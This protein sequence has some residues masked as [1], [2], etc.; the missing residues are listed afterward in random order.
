LKAE[1]P[2]GTRPFPWFVRMPVKWLVFA[3]V[4]LLVLFPNPAQ[5]ARH[6]SRLRNLQ[7]M[8]EPNA[9]ELAPFEEELRQRLAKGTDAAASQPA[10]DRL[11]KPNQV[12]ASQP[13]DPNHLPARVIQSAIERFVF[14]KVKYAWDWDVWG[15]ADYIPTIHEM[16]A[17]A[18]EYPD[19][20]IRE[21]C[22]GRAVMAAS[23][24]KRMGYDASI[25]TDL[26]HVW[27]TT[28]EGEWMGPGGPKT[29]A[30]GP[31]GNRLNLASVWRNVPVSLSYGIAVFP[32][33]REMILLL[34]AYAL[35]ICRRISWRTA[36]VAGVLLLQGLL[37]MRCGALAFAGEKDW[38]AIVGMLHVACGFAILMTA[39]HRARR[40]A[41]T[42]TSTAEDH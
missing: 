30:S 10:A 17:K 22:D 5:L 37:F 11:V 21:D 42:G 12:A 40:I 19:G 7:A 6:I 4:T 24:M 15:S 2:R 1:P 13:V 35:M 27:V 33:A 31:Q 39:S 28:P 20:Q 34:T 26:R 14:E 8:I 25:V 23:L 32:F 36:A 38:P 18:K 9:P 29:M 41:T 3:A 16:F